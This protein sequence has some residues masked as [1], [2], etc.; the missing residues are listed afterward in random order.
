MSWAHRC[1]FC[2]TKF[3][4]SARNRFVDRDKTIAA[5]SSQMDATIREAFADDSCV[6]RILA[7]LT[8]S[9]NLALCN[10]CYTRATVSIQAAEAL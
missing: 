3:D 7:S 2:D 1:A 6:L 5:M 4:D 8:R 10:Y 9:P